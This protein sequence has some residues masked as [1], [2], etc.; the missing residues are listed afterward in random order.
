MDKEDNSVRLHAINKVTIEGSI[1]NVFLLVFKFIAGIV[2]GSAAMIADAIHSLSDFLTD[3]VM[4]IFVRLSNKPQDKDHDFGHGKYETLATALIG[5]ALLVVGAMICIGGLE[6]I[7]GV[8]RGALLPCPGIIAFIAAV[9]SILSKEW[10]FQFTAKVGRKYNSQAVIANAWHHRSDALSSIGTALGTGLAILL[11]DKWTVLDPLTAVAVS[12]FI[13]WEAVKLIKQSSSELLE[14]SLPEDIERQIVDIAL[15]DKDLY[16]VHN[17][18]TRR[19]GNNFAIEMHI[20]MPGGTSLYEAHKHAT[21]VE[22]AIKRKFG[23]ETHVIIHLEPL[24]V[25]GKYVNPDEAR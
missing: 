7:M 1:I 2:G 20:R 5:I 10:C 19:I 6:K 11:G 22:N 17:L 13:V 12:G 15:S 3:I 21:N 23:A 25:N 14:A 9:V 24:K 16:E 8:V 4:L 18:R